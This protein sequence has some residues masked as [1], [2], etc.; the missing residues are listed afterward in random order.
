LPGGPLPP[1]VAPVLPGAGGPAATPGGDIPDSDLLTPED[2]ASKG[3]GKKGPKGPR[4]PV[5]PEIPYGAGYGEPPA[6]GE[7]IKQWEQQQS[8]LEKQHDVAE[9]QARLN[10]LEQDNNA[11]QEDIQKAKNALLRAQMEEQKS[12]LTTTTKHTDDMTQLGA[13]IDE[14]FGLS[15][16]LPGL[17]DNL[18]KFLANLAFAP[19]L[20]A[21][22]GVEAAGGGVKGKGSGLVGL[23]AQ[24][25]GFGGSE[26]SGASV[27]SFEYPGNPKTIGEFGAA[28]NRVGALYAF[29]NSMV[30]TPYSTALRNDC[31]GMVSRLANVALGLP[32]QVDF[33]TTGEGAWLQQHGFQSGV[34][35]P[36]SFQVGWNPAPGMSGH[37]AATLPGGVNA[38]QGGSNS[39][40]TLGPRAAGG[41]SSQFPQHAYLPMSYDQG[42]AVPI[43]AHEGEH[44]LTAQDVNA[45]GGQQGVY[46]FRAG[47]QNG[48]QSGTDNNRAYPTGP[49]RTTDLPGL[50]WING[51]PSI[52]AG[53]QHFDIGGGIGPIAPIDNPG[54]ATGPGA[55]LPP[56]VTRQPQIGPF[57][58]PQGIT[59]PPTPG[60]GPPAAAP[61]QQG[62]T[63]VGGAEPPKE[64]GGGNAGGSGGAI[65]GA[66][67]AALQGAASGLNALAPGAGIAAQIGIQEINRGIQY[68]G[69][70]AGIGV[71]ALG[72]TF[73]P[74]GESQLAA[75]GWFSRIAGG[76][77]SAK[78]ALPNMAGQ[79]QNM[80]AAGKAG[81]GGPTPEGVT[82]G[83][84][85]FGAL[86]SPY[87]QGSGTTNN[88][89]VHIENWNTT[90]TPD[91]EAGALVRHQI[92]A[93]L[94][95]GSAITGSR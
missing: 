81:A 93:G 34:G 54:G 94:A 8:I 12:E 36:G 30:G 38:E 17:A 45:M 32:P 85:P 63:R 13:K 51:Q 26:E 40:F 95:A 73:K 29:A 62:P 49:G 10:Q 69:Q 67:L 42:G 84:S 87:W 2:F 24:A 91:Q 16:G 4:L 65:G 5:A 75:S 7:S 1:G 72:E 68:A 89:G 35:P 28:G 61:G 3:K 55:P 56:G 58:V 64:P 71:Q 59:P 15:K 53:L 46:N 11:T 33:D 21:L 20:G 6:P 82:G 52:P 77:T 80:S 19:V 27:P 25:A 39:A 9:K 44:V 60:G 48:G 88:T 14:G 47:L 90:G 70:V 22:G 76:I 86:S 31:S 83:T 23:A 37:T 92:A 43:M 41:A 18:V 78:P 66:P 57:P 50:K 79:S 74:T